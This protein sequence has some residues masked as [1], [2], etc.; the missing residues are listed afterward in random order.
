MP[1][2]CSTSFNLQLRQRPEWSASIRS[3]QLTPRAHDVRRGPVR[4][5]TRSRLFTAKI[6]A[7][8][9]I[10]DLIGSSVNLVESAAPPGLANYP[11]QRM[12]SQDDHRFPIQDNGYYANEPGP[13]AY[14]HMLDYD[15][16]PSHPYPPV[17]RHSG[18]AYDEVPSS[19][20]YTEHSANRDRN[21]GGAPPLY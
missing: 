7:K 16:A 5:V 2:P 6:D 4:Q 21:F 15:Q 12:E 19:H 20:Q 14:G 18:L 17:Q 9:L 11:M 1:S 10:D 13:Y 3:L 8:E